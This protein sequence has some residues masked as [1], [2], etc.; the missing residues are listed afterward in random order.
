MTT[1]YLFEKGVSLIKEIEALGY[2][3][4]IVGGAVRDWLTYEVVHDIDIATNCPM[5]ILESK[6][7]TYKIGK[8]KDFGILSVVYKYSHFEVAQFR[9]DGNYSD[10]RRPDSVEIVKDFKEDASRRDFTINAMGLTCNSQIIDYFKGKN[11]LNDKIIRTV[12]NP[13][14]RFQED[15]LRMIRAARFASAAEFTIEKE[16][17]EAIRKLSYLVYKVSP[18]R[19]TGELIKAA[20]KT[21][22]QFAR[23]L[24]ILDDLNLLSKILPEITKLKEL[25][26][27]PEF[28]PEGKTVFDHV[29]KC[30]EVMGSHDSISKIAVLFHDVGKGVSY[31]E[32]SKGLTFHRHEKT[33]VGIARKALKRLKFPNCHT[34]SILFAV[35]NHMKLHA[36]LSMRPSKIVRLLDHPCF[37]ILMDVAWADEFSRGETFIHLGEFDENMSKA[38]KIKEEWEERAAAKPEKFVDGNRIMSIAGI[39]PGPL[40]GKIKRQVEDHIIDNG[41]DPGDTKTIDELILKAFTTEGSINVPKK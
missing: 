24:L 36:L 31:Q 22:P 26:H 17:K 28:H 12:G 34:E 32:T 4:Y 29:I 10:G 16:T 7:R 2:Q 37:P 40:V 39:E 13:E 27:K 38:L 9:S 21:G 1:N 18:E 30:V 14:G 15:H 3:A 5:E 23:F 35:R 25:D 11:D 41:I 8:S 6:F 33:G 19:V 20:S